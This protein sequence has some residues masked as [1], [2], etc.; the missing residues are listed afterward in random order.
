MFPNGN[1]AYLY[2][3]SKGQRD[4]I[5]R[6]KVS[7]TARVNAQGGWKHPILPELFWRS[8]QHWGLSWPSGAGTGKP[9]Q[10]CSWNCKVGS[11]LLPSV[12]G[13][14]AGILGKIQVGCSKQKYFLERSSP[15]G[16][17]DGGG[18]S[19]LRDEQGDVQVRDS[20]P[21]FLQNFPTGFLQKEGSLQSQTSL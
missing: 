1:S 4:V 12:Q 21:H 6:L 7:S 2:M 5:Q 3:D 19:C 9:Q 20:K 10:L 14:L 8:H 15:L 17:G 16:G 11:L 18:Q 13:G